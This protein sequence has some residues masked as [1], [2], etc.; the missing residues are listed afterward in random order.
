[1]RLRAMNASAPPVLLVAGGSRGIG[2]ATATLAAARGFD[3][4]IN[5]LRD[6]AAAEVVVAAIEAQGRAAIALQGDMACE[7]DVE[8]AFATVD[9]KLGTLTHLVYSCGI[10]GPHSRLEAVE[11]E[12]LREVLDLNVLGALLCTRAAIARMSLKHG[13]RGGAVVLLSS[14]AATIGGA[15]EYVWYAASKGAIDS[16]T[17]GL[18]RELAGDGIRV[19]AV[20][21]GIIATRI[22]PPGRI[23]RL[24]PT[25]PMARAGTAAEVAEAVVFLLSQASSYVTGTVLRVAGGR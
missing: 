9:R 20:A 6:S 22:H 14:A 12:T 11:T 3:V 25:T 18:A 13:G 2:A 21:P 17:L 4:A 19:N 23:D 7:R 8:R 24:A 10:T 15:G 5:Y 16:M 1:M